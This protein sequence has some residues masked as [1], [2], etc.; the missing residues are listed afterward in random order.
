VSRLPEDS[1]AGPWDTGHSTAQAWRRPAGRDRRSPSPLKAYGSLERAFA[2]CGLIAA[3][4]TTAGAVLAVHGY[5]AAPLVAAAS[6]ALLLCACLGVRALDRIVQFQ[7]GEVARVYATALDG[8]RRAVFERRRT[9]P[10]RMQTLGLAMAD[11]T[12]SLRLSVFG[13]D[14]VRNWAVAMRRALDDRA[15]TSRT[16]AAAMGED[17]N[18]IAAAATAS[19]RREAEIG[20]DLGALFAHAGR[21]AEATTNLADDTDALQASVRQTNVHLRQASILA[22]GLADN[23]MNA[24]RGVASLTEMTIDLLHAAEQVKAV[25]VRA[26]MVGMNA[27]IEAAHAGEA[28]RGFAVVAAEVRSLS[29][30]GQ[31]ALEAMLQAVRGLKNDAVAMTQTVGV[32]SEGVQAHGALGQA[33]S[34]AVSHQMEEVSR[35]V[36]KAG[37]AK[38]EILALQQRTTAMAR[39]ELGAGVGPAARSAIE[40]LPAHAE[41]IARILHDLPRFEPAGS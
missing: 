3:G 16:L 22:V 26:E 35:V 41:A 36:S 29:A 5:G 34:E 37:V 30:S 28:G 23:A 24:Q 8:P 7:R 27:G 25:L 1:N 2:A 20:E 15:A 32:I 14:H 17:A 21:A 9:D 33:L 38:G 11:L 18:A 39:H 31:Q 13:G 40:R 10:T 4:G 19:R 12:D 6:L